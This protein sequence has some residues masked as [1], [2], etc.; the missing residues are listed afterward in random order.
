VEKVVEHAKAL[1]I[2]GQTDRQGQSG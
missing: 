2:G 1:I